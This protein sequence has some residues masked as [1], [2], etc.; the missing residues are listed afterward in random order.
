MHRTAPLQK[1]SSSSKMSTVLRLRDSALSG[2]QVHLFGLGNTLELTI[3]K[4]DHAFA[5]HSLRMYRVLSVSLD[6]RLRIRVSGL[7]R[8]LKVT[9]SNHFLVN[10]AL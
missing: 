7:D 8:T 2:V 6:V 3:P 1:E 4:S 10:V 9:E 5:L